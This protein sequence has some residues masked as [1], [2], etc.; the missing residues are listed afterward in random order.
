[1]VLLFIV[2][3]VTIIGKRMC[4]PMGAATAGALLQR[5]GPLGRAGDAGSTGDGS[6]RG[7]GV[8]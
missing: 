3:V 1:M 6:H 5:P 2:F 7:L 4:L 8:C